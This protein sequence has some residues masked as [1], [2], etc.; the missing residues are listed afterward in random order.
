MM[1]ERRVA[2]VTLAA[3]ATYP[4]IAQTQQSGMNSPESEYMKKTLATG[5]L[6]LLTSQLALQKAS[7]PQVKE[8]AQFEVAEQETMADVLNSLKSGQATGQMKTPSEAQV[9]QNLT[10]EAAQQLQKLQSAGAGA[11]FDAEYVQGQTE[12]HRLLLATQ[13]EYLRAGKDAGA[14]NVAKLAR[15]QIKEHLKLLADIEEALHGRTA[16]QSR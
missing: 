10:S 3:L 6:S 4:A 11:A 8:F 9:K 2:L 5:S 13:E 14:L 1:I 16:S 15:T 7:H 12:G